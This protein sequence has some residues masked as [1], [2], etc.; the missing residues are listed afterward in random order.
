MCGPDKGKGALSSRVGSSEKLYAPWL[1]NVP[2]QL[3]CPIAWKG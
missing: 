2:T 3:L 1:C